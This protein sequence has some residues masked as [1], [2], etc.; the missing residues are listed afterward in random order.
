MSQ[1]RQMID[2]YVVILENALPRYSR[3]VLWPD[4]ER[5]RRRFHVAVG[6]TVS[7]K[8]PAAPANRAEVISRT[9]SF[10]QSQALLIENIP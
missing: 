9:L 1:Q 5:L 4:P 8:P 6:Q 10:P 2:H 3:H 7:P